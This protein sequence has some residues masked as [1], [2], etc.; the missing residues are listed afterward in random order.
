MI[1]AIVFDCFGVLYGASLEVL[2]A[3]APA[4]KAQE[5]RDINSAK[6]YGYITNR[7]YLA[8]IAA[9]LDM[10]PDEVNDV[11]R[12]RHLPNEAL[13]AEVARLKTHYKIGLLSNIGDEVFETLF[14]GRAKELFDEVVLSYREGVAKPNPEAFRLIA[15]RLDVP[16][17]ECVMV[18]DI[19]ANCEGA[20]VIGM[21][22]ILHTNNTLTVARIA[23]LA[24]GNDHAGAA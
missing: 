22:P 1:R 23:Q 3:M 7:E 18:D 2:V 24:E 12:R 9:A 20:E 21:H 15:Q 5:V 17:E 4:G 19:A 14:D 11:I 16:P 10:T 8:Q 13:I 6:D